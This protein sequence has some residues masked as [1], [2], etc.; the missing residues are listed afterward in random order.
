MMSEDER[1]MRR[2][3]RLAKKG[4]GKTSPNPMVGAIL[5]KGGRVV[6]EDI[7]TGL[8]NPMLK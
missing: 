5:V 6:S 4:K 1:W 8:E 3:I 7:I 2:A